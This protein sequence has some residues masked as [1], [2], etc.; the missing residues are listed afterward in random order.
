MRRLEG[1]TAYLYSRV[2]T[3]DQKDN[4]Y[5][6]PQ[7]KTFLYDFCERNGIEVLGYFEEDFT[8]T[9]FVR[10]K[11]KE[12]L[13]QLKKQKADYILFHKWDRF[14]RE[15][16]GIPEVEKLL[17]LGIQPNSISEWIDFNDP[18]YFL[19]LGIYILQAK[20][21]NAKRS[22]RTKDG[23]IGALKEGRNPNRAPIGY[24]NIKDPQNPKK[25]FMVK[26]P[27]KAPLIKKIFE[28]Y[29]TGSYSMEELR[30]KY[31]K[32]GIIRSKNQFSTMLSN[33]KYAGKIVVPAYKDYPK[34]IVN[35]LHEPI[36]DETLF[37]KVQRIKS[38]KIAG[39]INSKSKG[40]NDEALPL[41]GGILQC[42]RCG[43]NLTGSA[44]KS[45]SGRRIYYYHCHRNHGC[46]ENIPAE[47]ANSKL[48]ELFFVLKPNKR[49]VCLFKEILKEK[50]KVHYSDKEKHV[51]L[52]KNTKKT[53]EVKMDNLTEKY[54]NDDIDKSSYMRLKNKYNEELEEIT[55]ELSET[56][57][58]AN[59]INKF[60][61]F[62]VGLLMNLDLLYKNADT[63]VKRKIIRSIFAEKLVFENKIYRTP[64]YSEAVAL[65]FNINKGSGILYNKKGEFF[66]KLSYSVA[67][68]GL[69]P[70]TFGL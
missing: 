5:S 61:D 15:P 1:K 59:D 48:L 19:Y 8:S 35:G 58:Q 14:S 18:S 6:L 42:A 9:T 41:R 46:H 65:I 25:P 3:S 37:I 4:G 57:N 40:L 26:C 70:V 54:V 16:D 68:T 36:I 67:R 69:E 60:V 2:S 44:S 28:E 17:K 20:V 27:D 50:F 45:G 29:A 64:K 51:N 24:I 55:I 31:L 21:E 22:E 53:I 63:T 39:N 52:L 32:L 47:E 62:G 30:R 66:S 12:L 11:Y 49:V 13:N 10:P 7:Q 56:T 33:V 34:Q 43:R 38:G 23:I